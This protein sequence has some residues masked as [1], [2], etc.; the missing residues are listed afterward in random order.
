MYTLLFCH[1]RYF[2][3]SLF[4]P[5]NAL[6]K[7]KKKF[8][9]ARVLGLHRTSYAMDVQSICLFSAISFLHLWPHLINLWTNRPIVLKQKQLLEVVWCFLMLLYFLKRELIL[10]C[11]D[12]LS[13]LESQPKVPSSDPWHDVILHQC[14]M[15]CSLGVI[16]ARGSHLLYSAKND[17]MFIY[18]EHN[19]YVLSE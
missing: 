11:M 8:L 18:L 19:G 17:L 14:F 1:L 16:D 5:K 15:M 9:M 10:A 4:E 13:P 3:A 6:D 12:Q 7:P 2:R